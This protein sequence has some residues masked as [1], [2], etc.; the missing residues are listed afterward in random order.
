M[1]I[2]SLV[3]LARICSVV[4][5]CFGVPRSTFV[6]FGSKPFMFQKLVFASILILL[7]GVSLASSGNVCAQGRRVTV[8]TESGLQYDGKVFNIEKISVETGDAGARAIKQVVVINDGL[9]RT[10]LNQNSLLPNIVDSTRNEKE[11]E[12]WQRTYDG[13]KKGAAP[14]LFAEPFNDNGHRIL[15]VRTSEGR[16][17]YIQGITKL[18]PRYVEVQS[19]SGGTNLVPKG[20]DMSLAIGTIPTSVLK[21]V[22]ENEIVDPNQVTAWLD[23]PDFLMQAGRYS[24]AKDE[25]LRIAARFPEQK[26]QIEASR[27]IVLQEEAKQQLREIELTFDAGQTDLGTKWIKSID[28]KGLAPDTT[29]QLDDLLDQVDQTKA[30]REK[31]IARV[32]AA[33]EKMEGRPEGQLTE[34]QAD[35]LKRFKEQV[36]SDLNQ[37]N[38]FRLDSFAGLSADPNNKDQQNVALAISGWLLGSNNA[39]DNWAVAQ[40]LYS[41]LDL[42]SE[43]LNSSEEAQRTAILEQLAKFESSDV[44][45]LA[46]MLASMLPPKHDLVGDYSGREPIEFFV[47]LDGT[48]VDPEPR[49]YRCLVHLPTEYDPYKRY[50]MMLCLPGRATV[51]NHLKHW[52]GEFNEGLGVRYG[53]ASRNGTIVV[54][55]D[56][57]VSGQRR[58]EYSVREHLIVMKALRESMRRFSVDSDRVFLQGHGIGADVAYDVGTSHPEHW[59]GVIGV[60]A[61]GIQKYPLIYAENTGNELPIYAVVGERHIGSIRGCQD[62]WNK[63]LQSSKRNAC[64]V[65][66]YLGRLDE[67]FREDVPEAFKWMRAQRRRYPDKAGFEFSCKSIRPA[68]NYFWFLE[69]HGFP[70]KNIKWPELFRERRGIKALE[71]KGKIHKGRPNTFVVGNAGTGAT[72]WLRPD[73]FDFNHEI[74]VNGRGRSFTG[75][76]TASREVLLED[77]RTRADYQRPYWAKLDYI[78]GTW[79]P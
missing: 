62:A 37:H 18:N 27:L 70:L 72:L 14:F 68:D 10:F 79:M 3:G 45:F 75:S 4:S 71:I 58:A 7:A 43:Y 31:L 9:K 35:A 48:K 15:S 60:S 53:H 46:P 50:P 61:T 6:H 52:C 33:V 36:T 22:L 42:V 41:V 23:I 69:V 13:P 47:T 73:Y 2:V 59:A 11:L 30:K 57:R 76:V 26:Q 34:E 78:N 64:T 66:Q 32:V 77:A 21:G 25:L 63:W 17:Q 65:V 12:I 54:A 74:K 39:T 16:A 55:I 28:R 40:S 5:R 38:L 56:W 49:Q 19:L 24:D 67:Q 1:T 20:W 8:T 29:V 51:E 44:S